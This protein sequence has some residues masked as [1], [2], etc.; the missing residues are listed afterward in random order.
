MTQ[1]L[2][3]RPRQ[4]GHTVRTEVSPRWV[5]GYVDGALLF[6]TRAA[7]LL[8]ETG[9][10]PVYYVPQAD[11]R[12]ELLTPTEHAS[13]CPY[14]GDAC[15]WSINAPSG[16]RENAAWAYPERVDAE[17][18][19]LNG[20]VAF[21]W[22][23]VDAWFE[24]DEQIYVHPRDPYK[25]VDAIPSSRH[26]VVRVNGEVVAETHR[27]VVLFETGLPTRYYIPRLDV[28]QDLLRASEKR[29]ACPYKGEAGYFSVEVA[30]KEARDIAWHYDHP[31]AACDAIAG[32]I[33]FFNERVEL[34]VDGVTQEQPVTKWS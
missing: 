2:V 6:D 1:Q 23:H 4:P 21:Y 26:V 18:P 20:Y 14:K 32:H 8:F 22:R 16:V 34:V 7:L 13:H 33:A 12:M 17:A 25:R 15:Y 9:H 11:V 27:P 30:G 10:T 19:D 28:R 29:T 24:E 3:R 5:R 31:L